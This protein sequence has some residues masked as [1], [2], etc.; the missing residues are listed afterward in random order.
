MKN[1]TKIFDYNTFS[2]KYK[3]DSDVLDNI[4][5]DAQK[6]FEDDQMMIEL[7]VIRAIKNLIRKRDKNF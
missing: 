7:H 5:N 2:Q 6:E 4:I 1:K 3:I